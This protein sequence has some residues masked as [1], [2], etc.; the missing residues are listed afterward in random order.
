MT[1]KP[2]D[3]HVAVVTGASRGIGRAIA[4]ELASLGA[5]VICT[6]RTESP[7]AD[8]AGTLGDTVERITNAGGSASAHRADLL[9]AEE[10]DHLAAT[11]LERHG[12]VD[13][14]VNNAAYIG[15]AV[16]ESFW[17]MTPE[18]WTNM[19]ELNVNVPWRLSKLFATA[20]RAERRG[21]IVNLGSV[22]SHAPEP[23]AAVPLPG[24]GGLGAAYPTSKAALAQLTAHVG[25]EL[26][27]EGITMVALDPGFAA[28][29]SA[30]IFATKVGA[31]VAWAQP[32]DVA[33][34][35]T[36]WIATRPD[37]LEY[38]GS[39]VVARELVDR[40]GLLASS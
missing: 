4:M 16:F 24:A 23:G 26:R 25:N 36:A 32:V 40:H 34:K 30:E 29:E 37:P 15:D 18:S 13:V 39:F 14:L 2:L 9:V 27:A 21:L 12:R 20:M 38:A 31:D 3:Q 1:T 19:I 28:T 33:A 5:H 8:I 35:A 7:R 10:L 6:S 22:A 17:E 11:V